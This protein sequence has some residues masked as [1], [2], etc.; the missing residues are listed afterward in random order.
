MF[1]TVDVIKKRMA[2]LEPKKEML[3]KYKVLQD[4]YDQYKAAEAL[5]DGP[6]VEDNDENN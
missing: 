4:L 3:E 1:K 6:D 5:L 2:I